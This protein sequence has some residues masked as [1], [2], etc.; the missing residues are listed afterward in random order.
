MNRFI[1]P[2]LLVIFLFTGIAGNAKSGIQMDVELPKHPRLLLFKGEES[3]IQKNINSDKTW[4]KINQNI[5]SWCDTLLEKPPVERV[6]TGKR[7]LGPAR[8]CLLRVCYLSYGWRMTNDLRYLKRAENEMLNAASFKDWN[9]THFLDVAEFTMALAIG[10]DWLYNDLSENSLK[11]IREA[12]IKNGLEPSLNEEYNWWLSRSHN[13]NQV[14]NA[15]MTY[16]ALAIYES[17]PDF[18]WQIINRAIEKIQLPMEDYN[19]D[20]AYNEG[21]GYWGY[22]TTFNVMFL[23]A[24]EKIYNTDFGLLKYKGFL[25]TAGYLNNM[26]GLSGES[27]NYSDNGSRIELHPAMFWFAKKLN[28][29][30]LLWNEKPILDKE[31]IN[32][33][34][35]LPMVMIFGAEINLNKIPQPKKDM[36]VGNGK[37]PV[38][39]MRTSW[40][41]PNGIFVGIKGGSSSVNHSHMDIGSF[42]MEA[43][44]VRWA[45]DFGAQSYYS[46]ESKGIDLWNGKQDS[47]RWQVFRYNNCAHNT[48]TINDQYQLVKGYAPLTGYSSDKNFMNATFDLTEIYQDQLLQAKRGI[49]I[50]DRQYVVVRDELTNREKESTVRWT[51]LT[52]AEVNITENNTVE[53]TKDGEKLILKVQEPAI[54][55]MK[56]WSTA[57]TNDYDAPNPGTTLVGFEFNLPRGNKQQLTVFLIP[58]KAVNKIDINVKPIDQWNK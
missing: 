21:Y 16:G 24:I 29:N 28:D 26:V 42:V 18:A 27:F 10:Y 3:I 38:A 44:G 56:T 4:E 11:T 23:S 39:L 45:M 46:L 20:G 14:C 47:Q 2:A 8:E 43:D 34:K 12:I 49:A 35:F 41:D 17:N 5:I 50:V 55:N 22:G 52:S 54:I 40:D 37:N 32:R 31:L 7:L 6:L 36:W 57:P 30:S 51:M 33:D 9:P 19:P 13:W 48:L 25:K 1:K 15:G 58:E 53:L